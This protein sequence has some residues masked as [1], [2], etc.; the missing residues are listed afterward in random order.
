MLDVRELPD[1]E[2]GPGEV[3]IDIVA[4]AVNP[5][6]LMQRE[7]RYPPPPGASDILGLECAGTVSAVG[8][9]TERWH[10]RDRVCAL[11]T[12]GGYADKVAV[13]EGQVLP[14][15]D[16]MDLTDAAALPEV[17]STVWA[18]VFMA[19]GLQ[20]DELFLMHGGGGGIGMMAIQ[21]AH[22]LGARVA[23]TV[24]SADKAHACRSLGAD[25]AILYK[26]QDFVAEVRSLDESGADVILD[27][28]GAAY[29]G[30]NVEALAVEG[31]LVVIGLQ[32]GAR[33]EL[34]L[35]ALMR[36]RCA[37]I[38]TTLRARPPDEKA[39][40]IASVEANA[41]PLV[42]DKTVFPVVHAKVPLDEVRRAHELVEAGDH[43]GKVVL[44]T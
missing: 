39:A 11:L 29:L 3:V 36:K 1:P 24:G 5:A 33:G 34:D 7:G 41:W 37:V 20:P 38:A 19:A 4:S 23:T 2:P 40:I 26:E 42:V 27:S 35:N 8:E 10:V 14:V 15:P 9:G 28:I 31:R 18:N 16:D 22:A 6:D 21:L 25:L 44:T 12:A 17:V 32:G 30:R 43:I 13:P